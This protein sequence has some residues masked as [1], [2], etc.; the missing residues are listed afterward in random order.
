M[1]EAN[2]G[3]RTR[4]QKTVTTTP[5]RRV[6]RRAQLADPDGIQVGWWI[7]DHD[8]LLMHCEFTGNHRGSRSVGA[9]VPYRSFRWPIDSD[10]LGPL[11]AACPLDRI[12]GGWSWDIGRVGQPAFHE[13]II[14]GVKP[15]TW[16]KDLC[17][18]YWR[19][20]NAH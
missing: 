18:H 17:V 19:D 16:Q 1:Y 20:G 14:R 11:S 7:D 4:I 6:S 3:L 10:Y 9:T 8:D 13:P 2:I 12:A 15:L 5:G